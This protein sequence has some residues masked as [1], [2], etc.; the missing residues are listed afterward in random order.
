MI[1]EIG[2]KDLINVLTRVT[3]EWFRRSPE[4]ARI[5]LDLQD[6]GEGNIGVETRSVDYLCMERPTGAHWASP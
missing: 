5:S 1:P 2:N 6:Q 3:I 4:V